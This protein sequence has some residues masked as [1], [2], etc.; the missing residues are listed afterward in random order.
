ML[1]GIS[2]AL[3]ACVPHAKQ[4][5]ADPVAAALNAPRRL[6]A[7][8]AQRVIVVPAYTMRSGDP[9]R[10]AASIARPRDALRGLDSAIADEF[11]AR[12]L[13]PR[14]Y[15]APDLE[16]A[17]R[18]NPTYSPDPHALAEDELLGQ[19]EVG[20]QYGAQ[21]GSQLRVLIAIEPDARVVLLP[22]ELWFE[23]DGDGRNGLA[24]LKLVLV[25]A[26]A[27]AVVAVLNVRSDPAAV[28]GPMVLKSLA[29]HVADLVVG[30]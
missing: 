22:V 13:R 26:R 25:D 27:Q 14:W 21:L 16:H 28:F 2:A 18:I 4:S 7:L 11:G 30:P 12:G 8:A 5:P 24:A 10:W 1:V 3:I 9:L 19:L 29:G 17:F 6:S 20:R 15:F 23:R